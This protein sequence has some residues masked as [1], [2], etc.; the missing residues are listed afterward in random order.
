MKKLLVGLCV[1]LAFIAVMMISAFAA[2][3]P[4]DDAAYQAFFFTATEGAA[5]QPIDF[6]KAV[7]TG[8][9][10]TGSEGSTRPG[11]S[12]GTAVYAGD[13]VTGSEGSTRPGIQW[14]QAK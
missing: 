10:V 8:D 13:N 7:Y 5:K 9:N 4:V 2:E 12:F 11:I 14:P 3:K 6:G 1:G